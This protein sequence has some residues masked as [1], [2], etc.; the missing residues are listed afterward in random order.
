MPIYEFRCLTCND[1]VEFLFRSSDEPQE[2]LCPH[3][4]GS[5]LERVLSRAGRIVSGSNRAAV[6]PNVNNRQCQTGSCSTIEFPG[7]D[8]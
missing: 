8:D 1:I 6:Q 5:D 4:G 3:C 2:M 7:L